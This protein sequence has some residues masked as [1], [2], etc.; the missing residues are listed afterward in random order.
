MHVGRITSIQSNIGSHL[1]H[2]QR[3]N[4]GH[5]VCVYLDWMV[6]SQSWISV[7]KKGDGFICLCLFIWSIGSKCMHVCKSSSCLFFWFFFD[8]V[9]INR[10]LYDHFFSLMMMTMMAN[11]KSKSKEKFMCVCVDYHHRQHTCVETLIIFFCCQWLFWSS[12]NL[13]VCYTGHD[14]DYSHLA[15]KRNEWSYMCLSI[16]REDK[17][18]QTIYPPTHSFSLS[19]HTCL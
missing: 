11:L 1:R 18:S 2:T 16:Y 9:V 7:R 14:D 12:R 5:C 8:T 4:D 10:H 3:E 13:P 6:K 15:T 17:T 19:L